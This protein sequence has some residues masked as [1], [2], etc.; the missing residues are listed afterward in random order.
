M[1]KRIIVIII[2]AV[3]LIIGA[4]AVYVNRTAIWPSQQMKELTQ[5]ETDLTLPKPQERYV[6][7]TGYHTDMKGAKHYD[8][9]IRLSYGDTGVLDILR[10]KLLQNS[11]KEEQV[12]PIESLPYQYF[13]FVRGSGDSMQCITGFVNPKDTDG[14][15]LLVTLQASGSYGCNTAP[16]T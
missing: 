2:A 11:W 9:E 3:L 12:K 15:P 4:V 1:R 10:S 5:L 6:D 16:G 8:R 14:T 13:R 7:D